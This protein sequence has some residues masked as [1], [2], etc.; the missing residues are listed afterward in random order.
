MY[1]MYFQETKS[2]LYI[3]LCELH[4]HFRRKWFKILVTWWKLNHINWSLFL[5]TLT[6]GISFSKIQNQK[7]ENLKIKPL[8]FLFLLDVSFFSFIIFCCW[9]ALLYERNV[10]KWYVINNSRWPSKEYDCFST[11]SVLPYKSLWV[12]KMGKIKKLVFKLNYSLSL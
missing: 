4:L 1:V 8:M 2:Y 7:L 10:I 11:W 5:L 12:K 3:F 6:R 9:F